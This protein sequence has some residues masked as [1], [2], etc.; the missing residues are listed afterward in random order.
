MNIRRMKKTNKIIARNTETQRLEHNKFADDQQNWTVNNRLKHDVCCHESARHTVD[1]W[2]MA[3]LFNLSVDCCRPDASSQ[4]PTSES[5]GDK[6]SKTG[7]LYV[8]FVSA[9]ISYMPLFL[10]W[11][12]ARQSYAAI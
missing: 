10:F 2:H 1:V 7:A 4:R 12:I 6:K 9:I 11:L 3:L 8:Q 5:T